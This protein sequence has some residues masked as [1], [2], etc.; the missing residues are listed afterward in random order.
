M[1]ATMASSANTRALSNRLGR[2]DETAPRGHNKGQPS[3]GQGGS[4][5]EWQTTWAPARCRRTNRQT[6]LSWLP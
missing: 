2:V 4:P 5:E 1:V 3:H 6:Q